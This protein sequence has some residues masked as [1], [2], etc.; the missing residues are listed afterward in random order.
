MI[1]WQLCV[2]GMNGWERKKSK[3]VHTQ[4]QA[5]NSSSPLA[6]TRVQFHDDQVQLLVVQ[7]SQIAIYD[8]SKLECVCHVR[9]YAYT[10]IE[11]ITL[12][13]TFCHIAVS[14]FSSYGV[15]NCSKNGSILSSELKNVMWP[16][17]YL[18]CSGHLRIQFL[19]VFR[20]PH[21][22]VTIY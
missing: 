10:Y 1:C 15:A 22:H 8:A 14:N 16:S 19:F 18:H 11:L 3:S 17:E 12:C 5:G 13:L 4:A 21:T 20:V 2:W 6:D 7:E 9:S